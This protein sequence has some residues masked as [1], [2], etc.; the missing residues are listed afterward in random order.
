[1]GP[2]YD[3]C[4]YTAFGI[5]AIG[6][7]VYG[8]WSCTKQRRLDDAQVESLQEALVKDLEDE[9][10]D[11]RVYNIESDVQSCISKENSMVSVTLD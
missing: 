5:V 8:W 11:K 2:G 4:I 10:P 7:V 6:T 9:F 1:M 3:P